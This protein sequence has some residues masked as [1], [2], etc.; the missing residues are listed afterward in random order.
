M[1]AAV[2][3][4]TR[5][6][7]DKALISKQKRKDFQIMLSG[8]VIAF[9]YIYLEQGEPMKIII[10]SAVAIIVLFTLSFSQTVE[11]KGRVVDSG[12]VPVAGTILQLKDIGL[13]DTTG[14]DGLFQLSRTRT[15]FEIRT[16]PSVPEISIKGGILHFQVS[17]S[18]ANVAVYLHDING[19]KIATLFNGNLT[20]GS[21]HVS[22]AGYMNNRLPSALYV[23]S[24]VQGRGAI[25]YK[26]ILVEGEA[27]IVSPASSGSVTRGRL[28]RGLEGTDTLLVMRDNV[29]YAKIAVLNLID[30]L[31]DI[32]IML[33]PV[34]YYSKIN[35]FPNYYQRD[36]AYGGLLGGGSAECG[37]TS[38]SNGLMWLSDHGFPNLTPHTSD[39]KKDQFDVIWEIG[40]DPYMHYRDPWGF[41]NGLRTYI[42]D[43]GYT[44]D[45]LLFY[46][47]D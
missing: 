21:H 40:A 35:E 22:M 34:Y 31:A 14:T 18:D 38:V 25:H 46:G 6:M 37:P 47:R 30:S 3:D 5:R 42:T 4:S 8:T 44:Y 13:S 16:S 7:P 15:L 43:K 1:R 29:L 33:M 2:Y 11:L 20:Q 9:I 28:G 17:S 23:L 45:T 26:M 19:R 12:L 39:R 27:I 10:K 24:I 32:Q 36:T 41:T